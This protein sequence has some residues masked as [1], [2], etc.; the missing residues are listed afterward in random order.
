M[1]KM[2]LVKFFRFD[3]KPLVTL[4]ARRMRVIQIS[5]FTHTIHRRVQG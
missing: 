3:N 5:D 1:S 4:L 2:V